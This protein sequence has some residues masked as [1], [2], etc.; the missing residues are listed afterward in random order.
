MWILELLLKIKET[1]SAVIPFHFTFVCLWHHLMSVMQC[2]YCKFLIPAGWDRPI[3]LLHTHFWNML[4]S[5][6][7]TMIH[8]LALLNCVIYCHIAYCIVNMQNTDTV[9]LSTHWWSSRYVLI[10][11]LITPSY[12]SCPWENH[13]YLEQCCGHM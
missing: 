1:Q 4:I 5:C 9:Y 12:L 11:L 13:S 2:K 7:V 3:N 10:L 6:R 8:F